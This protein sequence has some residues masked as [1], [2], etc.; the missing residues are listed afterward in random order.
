MFLMVMVMAACNNSDKQHDTATVDVLNQPPFRSITDSIN[1]DKDNADLLLKRGYMLAQQQQLKLAAADYRAAWNLR[2]DEN[3]GLEL[4]NVLLME[5]ESSE[6]VTFLKKAI[7]E[8]PD[9]M[10]FAR[11]LQE[12]YVVNGQE[13]LAWKAMNDLLAKDSLNFENWYEQGLLYARGRDTVHAIASF[14]RSFKLRP[15][16]T[17]GLAL[18]NLLAE[19]AD[20]RA[21]EVC[22]TLLSKDS[23][24]ELTDAVYLKGVYY[25][26]AGNQ[27]QA[28]EQFEECI[29]RDWKFTEAYIEKGIIQF[30]RN[31][32]DAALKTFQLAATVS[33]TYPDAYFWQ[34]RC[35]EAIGRRDDALDNYLRALSLDKNF[36]QAREGIQRLKKNK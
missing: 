16:Q 9:N 3:T 34:G 4:V 17:S 13:D 22:D 33:N 10:D 11:R 1:N 2:H 6:A 35:Y 7:E 19:K 15:T 29:K 31:N 24:K 36:D 12:A 18:A 21:L 26:N 30:E 5:G 14:E 8:Y 23:T 25:E 27:A 28:M 20:P 32:L